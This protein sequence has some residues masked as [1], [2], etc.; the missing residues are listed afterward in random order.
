[1]TQM[2]RNEETQQRSFISMDHY[3]C[4][5]IMNLK[6]HQATKEVTNFRFSK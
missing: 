6:V 2:S 1:M 5:Y 4:E 3:D